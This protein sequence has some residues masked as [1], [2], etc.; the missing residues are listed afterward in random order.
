MIGAKFFKA[1]NKRGFQI[2]VFRNIMLM[3]AVI[4]FAF[5]LSVLGS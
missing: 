5:S 1:L 2:K 3:T 4:D